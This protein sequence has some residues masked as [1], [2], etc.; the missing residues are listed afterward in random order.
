MKAVIVSG[1]LAQ[2]HEFIYPYYRVMEAG[3][4]LDYKWQLPL[5]EYWLKNLKKK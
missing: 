2:D 5:V 1:A 3:F 4:D